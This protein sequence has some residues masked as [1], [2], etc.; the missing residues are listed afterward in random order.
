MSKS[1][2]EK[3]R[4]KIR[5][6]IT[7]IE[8]RSDM[9][10][11]KKVS[12]ISHICCATCAGIAI[13]P[14]PFADIFILTPIQAYFATRIAAIRGVRMSESEA[15]DWVKEIIGI[16][17][18]GFIAQQLAIGVWKLVTFG[19]G[20]LLTLP[21]VYALS[22]AIMKVADAYFSGK[23][24]GEKLSDEMIKDIWKRA[25]KEGKTKG[26]QEEDQIKGKENGHDQHGEQDDRK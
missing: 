8:N 25:F 13:Q 16:M 10:D 17:G 26:Q 11:D 20:G 19:A 21:L 5:A 15:K 2:W 4:E 6:E 18:L 12:R 22:F 7:E 3:I 23:S 24:R 1:N 14:I 9:T